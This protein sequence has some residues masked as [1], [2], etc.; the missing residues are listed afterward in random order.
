MKFIAYS[1]LCSINSCALWC[2]DTH[3]QRLQHQFF[4]SDHDTKPQRSRDRGQHIRDNARS[5]GYVSQWQPLCPQLYCICHRVAKYFKHDQ[6]GT[7]GSPPGMCPVTDVAREE[8][9]QDGCGRVRLLGEAW[10]DPEGG[11]VVWNHGR[12]LRC[13]PMLRMARARF[14]QAAQDLLHQE[15]CSPHGE[16]H[17]RGHS[18]STDWAIFAGLARTKNMAIDWKKDNEY[19]KKGNS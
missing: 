9:L 10:C 19:I 16:A 15:Q 1:I 2:V 12:L 4:R 5:H 17:P 8:E 6:A 14:L 11:P 7:M 3:L 13:C 18:Q